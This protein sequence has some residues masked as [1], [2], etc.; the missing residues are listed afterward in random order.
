MLLYSTN[1]TKN[2]TN[3][4]VEKVIMEQDKKVANKKG[5]P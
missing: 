3:P 5:H 4:N 1:K 2:I